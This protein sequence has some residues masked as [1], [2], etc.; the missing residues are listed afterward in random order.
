MSLSDRRRLILALAA[1]PL[2]ACGFTPAYAP[3]G[4]G[5]A[6]RG[7]VRAADP[8][9]SQEFDFVAGIETRLGRPQAPLFD[10]SYTI[11]TSERGAAR[12]AGLGATRI[13]RFGTV[14]YQLTDRA[15]GAVVTEGS[16]RN[17]TNYS[18]TDTQ[19]ASRRA[20]EDAQS[21]LM[22]ILADQVAARLVAA[23]TE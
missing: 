5:Q 4:A 20:A 12:G 6:L 19:L 8:R 9:T 1:L 23:M 16:L 22:R 15:T 13:T 10:L 17:F 14:A 18:T 11:T 2:A 7:R 21:R 3:G